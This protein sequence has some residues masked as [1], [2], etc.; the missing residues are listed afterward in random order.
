MNGGRCRKRRCS[1]GR[2]SSI[3][4][5]EMSHFERTISVA[6]CDL[7]EGED[8]LLRTERRDDLR[9]WVDRDVE[10]AVDPARDR[11]AQLRQAGGARIRRDGLDR[12][13]E[14]FADERG[15][16][17]AR[18]AHSEVDQ[19]DTARDGC[20]LP[21][22]ETGERVLR[23]LAQHGGETHVVNATATAQPKRKR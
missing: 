23:E 6:E 8:R 10:A 2:T 18:V 15:R 3:V 21:V 7:R 12:R 4:I 11:L 1:S 5:S 19:L 9:R 13:G 16:H 14:C 17:L 22:V 20:G